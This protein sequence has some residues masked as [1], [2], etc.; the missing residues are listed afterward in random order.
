MSRISM[1]EVDAAGV[2]KNGFDYNLQVWVKN[3]IV[4]ICGHP[5]SMRSNGRGCC[6]AYFL[7]GQD[8]R[9]I[10]GHEVRTE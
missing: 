3:W 9:N 7:T 4:Q 2:V 10:D 1:D 6:E 8:I 5:E